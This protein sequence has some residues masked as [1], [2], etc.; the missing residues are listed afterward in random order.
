MGVGSRGGREGERRRESREVVEEFEGEVGEVGP[1][2]AESEENSGPNE[3]GGKGWSM[4]RG[5]R[6]VRWVGG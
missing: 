4:G 5:S 6:E 2:P 1:S 3:G